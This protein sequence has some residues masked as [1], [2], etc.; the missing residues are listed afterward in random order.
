MKLIFNISS[1]TDNITSQLKAWV[2]ICIILI[3]FVL[4]ISEQSLLGFFCL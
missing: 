3:F 2:L 4:H 1:I